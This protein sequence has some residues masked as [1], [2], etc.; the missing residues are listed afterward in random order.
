MVARE[1]PPS[2]SP[3]CKVTAL[4]NPDLG[5]K[6]ICPN[7]QTKFYDLNR[8]PAVCPKCGHAFDPE[9]ALKSRRVRTRA[10]DYED[11]GE[12]TAAVVVAD[13]E[14]EEEETTPEIDEAA[15]ETVIAED[16]DEGDAEPG[17]AAPPA[18]DIGVDFAE[19]ADIA[20]ED[21]EDVPFLEDE[22]E[23]DFAE[24]IEVPDDE[25]ER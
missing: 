14:L 5:Q 7:D 4:P 24:D 23:D 11:E 1:P 20:D 2:T 17:A 15:T 25:E 12:K 22:E 16:E 3:S 21:G 19:D 8:R 10:P 9:E 18:D 13:D 6:L